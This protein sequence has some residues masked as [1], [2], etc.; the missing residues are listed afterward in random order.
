M[1]GS[2]VSDAKKILRKI[3]ANA[4]D[5]TAASG[6]RFD[7]DL[8]ADLI[9]AEASTAQLGDELLDMA[10]SDAVRYVDESRREATDEPSLFGDFDAVVAIGDGTRRRKGSCDA[11]DMAKHIAIISAN[12]AAVSTAAA[13]KQAEYARLLPYLNDGQT[14]EQAAASWRADNPE[15]GE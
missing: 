13:K 11:A 3:V 15:L 2:P 9:R 10:I 7:L 14:Y 5:D 12:A 8:I 1:N 4:Y 6:E